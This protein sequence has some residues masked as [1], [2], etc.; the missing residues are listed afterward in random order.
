MWWLVPAVRLFIVCHSDSCCAVVDFYCEWSCVCC[1]DVVIW[2][3][4]L[5]FV[6][7]MLIVSGICML[8]IVRS[9]RGGVCTF[10]S[11]FCWLLFSLVSVIVL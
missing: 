3:W 6:C 11:L 1:S 9:G 2:L 7:Y 10:M 8:V 5:V 4:L